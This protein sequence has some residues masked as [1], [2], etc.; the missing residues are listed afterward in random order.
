VLSSL[1]HGPQTRSPSI[2]KGLPQLGAS[3]DS[4]TIESPSP[5]NLS[6]FPAMPPSLGNS[7]QATAAVTTT[8]PTSDG[9]SFPGHQMRPTQAPTAQASNENLDIQ[10][11]TQ[12]PSGVDQ[13][14]K[15]ENNSGKAPNPYFEASIPKIQIQVAFS[16]VERGLDDALLGEKLKAFFLRV[17]A[18]GPNSMSFVTADL[19]VDVETSSPLVVL[20]T[21]EVFYEREDHPTPD[22]ITAQLR[23][24]FSLW[25]TD[26]LE[27]YLGS[28]RVYIELNGDPVSSQTNNAESNDVSALSIILSVVLILIAVAMFSFGVFTCRRLRNKT[29]STNQKNQLHKKQ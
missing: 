8:Q 3:P 27:E 4:A 29:S 12:S 26:H 2:L 23:T 20:L 22:D 6:N 25:G 28:D 15:G 9:Q 21:G 17:L 16:L 11:S 24:Y 1:P 14:H 18:S 19:F 10:L 7:E 13:Q 5:L